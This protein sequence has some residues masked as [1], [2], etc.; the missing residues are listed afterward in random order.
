MT[1]IVVL[2]IALAAT[3]I[4]LYLKHG[5]TRDLLHEGAA[6][7]DEL[8]QALVQHEDI[9]TDALDYLWANAPLRQQEIS[10]AYNDLFAYA[11]APDCE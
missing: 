4:A 8:D 6:M 2:A 7:Y 3:L 9:I 5:E 11:E 1:T 10:E